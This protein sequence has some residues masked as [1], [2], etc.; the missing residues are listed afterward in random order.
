[1]KQVK[2]STNLRRMIMQINEH[3][4]ACPYKQ[5]FEEHATR[6]LIDC[7]ND[8]DVF[9]TSRRKAVYQQP[10]VPQDT[11]NNQK[12]HSS[13]H[14]E[15][16]RRTDSGCSSIPDHAYSDH[17]YRSDVDTFSDDVTKSDVG[18]GIHSDD[19]T[20]CAPSHFPFLNKILKS[21][22]LLRQQKLQREQEYD[23]NKSG[24]MGMA[25]SDSGVV[26]QR[27]DKTLDENVDNSQMDTKQPHVPSLTDFYNN[28]A[29]RLQDPVDNLVS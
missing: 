23:S 26:S 2:Y 24:G 7:E 8:Y 20:I 28:M 3:N 5:T 13:D 18:V 10:V 11:G 4:I 6:T 29:N 16:C 17:T 14:T 12:C 21:R 15:D 22:T 19:D 1:M 9:S 25:C 27:S